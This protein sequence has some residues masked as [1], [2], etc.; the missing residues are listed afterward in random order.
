MPWWPRAVEVTRLGD[1]V[2]QSPHRRQVRISCAALLRLRDDNRYVLFEAR[3]RPGA[4]SPPGGVFKYFGPAA[5][6]LD[7]LGFR[8]DR[9][10]QSSSDM[11]ADL[12]GLLPARSLT[13]FRRWF[14][15]G[16]YR[17]DASECLRRKLSE[18]LTEIGYPGLAHSVRAT[19]FA[20]LR[21][22]VEGLLPVPGQRYRQWRQLEVYDLM[23]ADKETLKLRTE[24]V[25][26]TAD[27]AARTV[28]A[29][30]PDDIQHG[31]A[32][33]SLLTPT[34]SYLVG[35]RRIR[36]DIPPVR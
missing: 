18:E 16:A 30:T 19:R 21:T 23:C 14:T 10:P 32:G 8:A 1:P 25:A 36:Y 35:D 29:A 26:L 28:I 15:T 33:R 24:L 27:A 4:F 34:T 9:W 12:R 20:H 7:G 2:A 3:S 31:R 6:L 22:I 13:S 5:E 11:R 17:E